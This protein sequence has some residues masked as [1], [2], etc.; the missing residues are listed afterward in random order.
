MA[1]SSLATDWRDPE[2]LGLMQGRAVLA[3][4]LETVMFAIAGVSRTTTQTHL[5]VG[6]ICLGEDACAR[7]VASKD[8]ACVSFASWSSIRLAARVRLGN[9][10][11][12]GVASTELI[13]V[14]GPRGHAWVHAHASGTG[15]VRTVRD[16]EAVHQMEGSVERAFHALVAFD[17]LVE[18]EVGRDPAVRRA[19]SRVAALQ[20]PPEDF[21][22]GL[23]AWRRA[24]DRAAWEGQAVDEDTRLQRRQR[25]F[26]LLGNETLRGL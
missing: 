3:L 10:E 17:R 15:E 5:R 26:R 19:H 14:A 23:A 25:V 7:L 16:W 4:A 9:G 8:C 12:L 21:P 6:H 2:V 1:D 24:R 18:A 13:E 11:R 22:G 20:H